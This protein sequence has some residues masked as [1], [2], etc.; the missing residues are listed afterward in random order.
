VDYSGKFLIITAIVTVAVTVIDYIVP[1]WGTKKWGG[2]RAG[3][4]GS[5]IGLLLGLFFSPV[6]IIIGP[7]AGAVVGEL[8]TGRNTNVALRAGFGSFIGFLFGT[9]MQFAVCMV[10][11]YYFFKELIVS[12]FL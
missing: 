10:F 11:T 2:S 12:V 3:A 1:V 9:I 5:A 6:G 8:I 7:F 4:I